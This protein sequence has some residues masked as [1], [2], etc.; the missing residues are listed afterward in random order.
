MKPTK[1]F[2]LDNT[3]FLLQVWTFGRADILQYLSLASNPIQMLI[4]FVR[5]TGNISWLTCNLY[6]CL[7]LYFLNI[8]PFGLVVTEAL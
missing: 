8:S 3:T 2:I 4:V 1:R 6:Y 7:F 5:V